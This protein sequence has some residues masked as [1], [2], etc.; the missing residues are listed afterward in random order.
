MTHENFMEK[1]FKFSGVKAH[2]TRGVAAS[3]AL[4]HNAALDDRLNACSR[5]SYSTFTSF[6]LKDAAL[7]RDKMCN[8]DPVVCAGRISEEF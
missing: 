7:Q 8:L 5:K 1:D 3:M 6:Y 2:Q 4:L